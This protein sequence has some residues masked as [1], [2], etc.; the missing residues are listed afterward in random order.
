MNIGKNYDFNKFNIK[1]SWEEEN[2]IT[3]F[4][5]KRKVKIIFIWYAPKGEIKVTYARKT[6]NNKTTG[7]ISIYEKC[8]NNNN[9]NII[10]Y[11]NFKEK[12]INHSS[13][14]IDINLKIYQKYFIRYLFEIGKIRN[15]EKACIFFNKRFPKS[16]FILT[17]QN[18]KK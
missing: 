12:I 11:E 14:K 9:H 6:K 1:Y 17:E 4:T 2:Y 18:I 13:D 8:K 7:I 16:I 5:K 10:E 15:Y 3:E